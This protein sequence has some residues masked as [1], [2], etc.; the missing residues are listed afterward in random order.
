MLD[1]DCQHEL[2]F[3]VFDSTLSTIEQTAVYRSGPG[4]CLIVW[5]TSLIELE[6]ELTFEQVG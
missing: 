5:E 1:G 2:I 3:D 6:W 4:G